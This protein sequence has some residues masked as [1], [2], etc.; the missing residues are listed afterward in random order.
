MDELRKGLELATEAELEQLTRILFARGVNP[1]DWQN[2]LPQA[3][4]SQN[5]SAWLD[6]LEKRFRYL[7]A[8]GLTVLKGRSQE[9]SYRQILQRVCQHLQI[10]Y[11]E[12]MTTTEMEAE[13]FLLLVSKTW[14]KLP[15]STRKSLGLKLDKSLQEEEIQGQVNSQAYQ[16]GMQFLLKGTGIWALNSVLKP[17]LLKKVTSYQTAKILL[18]R[19]GMTT[20]SKLPGYLLKSSAG[21]S[22]MLN[23]VSRGTLRTILAV[24]GPLLWTSLIAELGWKAI[25]TNYSRII[26]VIFTIAEIRLTRSEIWEMA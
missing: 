17:W 23:T 24:A 20:V 6:S 13:I 2:P 12:E 7:A 21:K 25:S 22:L 8:D 26:P 11:T 3:V 4:Q 10:K 14:R 19:G 9:L 1:L 5:W 16:E 18:T 15:Q